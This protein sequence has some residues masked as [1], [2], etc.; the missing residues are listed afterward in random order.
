MQN[1]CMDFPEPWRKDALLVQHFRLH[2]LEGS[3]SMLSSQDN[4]LSARR[5]QGLEDAFPE[6]QQW[7]GGPQVSHPEGHHTLVQRPWLPML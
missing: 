7:W 3:D 6:G 2:G 4:I 1:H 5:V